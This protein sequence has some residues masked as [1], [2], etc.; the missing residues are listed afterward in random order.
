VVIYHD[1]LTAGNIMDIISN[2]DIILDGTDNFSTKF[3]I[4]DACVLAGKPF[5]HGGIVRFEGQAFTYLPG[6]ACYRCFF[7]APPQA[8]I[9]PTCLQAGVLGSVTGMLG[10]IQA[11]EVLKF[12]TGIGELLI[13]RLLSF[14]AMTM[15]FRTISVKHDPHCPVCGDNP[16]VTSIQ[17]YGTPACA[18]NPFL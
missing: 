16:S 11:T 9:F 7:H 14:D 6:S 4:N 12:L 8:D 1:L 3:L 15:N 10:S 17:S 18:I 5:C 2:Y 13:G